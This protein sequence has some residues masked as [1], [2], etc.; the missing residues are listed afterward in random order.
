LKKEQLLKGGVVEKRLRITAICYS[1]SSNITF[2]SGTD[3]CIGQI[4]H[5]LVPRALGVPRNDL[6]YDDSTLTKTA[7]R[8]NLTIYLETGGNANV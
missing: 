3:L 6:F 8:Q 5:G 1:R 4:G 7:Q 2:L